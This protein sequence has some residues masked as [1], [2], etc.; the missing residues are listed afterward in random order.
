MSLIGWIGQAPR[1]PPAA[2][3]QLPF[4]R[5]CHGTGHALRG[6]VHSPV[7]FG[8]LTGLQIAIERLEHVNS[9]ADGG[10]NQRWRRGTRKQADLPASE[11]MVLARPQPFER[12][13]REWPVSAPGSHWKPRRGSPVLHSS[14]P[15]RSGTAEGSFGSSPAVP[16]CQRRGGS[17]SRS[18]LPELDRADLKLRNLLAG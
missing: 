2:D 16:A 4:C 14:E 11:E 13:S 17:T 10:S 3:R 8:R 5:R 9:A 15:F 1:R 7:A 6:V 12:R 18:G